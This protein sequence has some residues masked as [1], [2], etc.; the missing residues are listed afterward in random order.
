MIHELLQVD[1]WEMILRTT[2]TFFVLLTLA[3]ILGNKQLSQLTFFDYI[4]GITIGS[5]AADI[6]GRSESAFLNGLTSLIWWSCLAIL[7]AYIGLTSPSARVLFDG[8]PII[9]IKEGK[10]R[11]QSLKHAR[12]NLDDLSMMLR[13]QGVFSMQDVNY[14][15]LEPD[16]QVSIL[17][18]EEHQPVTKKDLAIPTPKSV[19]LP[20]EII[21]D[22]K[23]VK[24]NLQELHVTEAW[25]QA[26][27][28]K[29]GI[30][31]VEEVF[32][33]EIQKDGSL[34]VSKD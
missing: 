12:L 32:Y 18:K 10:I 8:Q 16:G 9:L 13:K 2:L 24:K 15:I 19:F 34:F 17:K 27:L 21:S 25:V 1:F 20:S 6:A 30:Q 22:G 11:K 31:S 14:A 3:R 29:H 5:I 7:I 33:A 23:I 4:T 26:Q 28:K